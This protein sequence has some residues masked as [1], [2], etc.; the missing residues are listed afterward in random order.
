M[1]EKFE[2]EGVD[3][4]NRDIVGKKKKKKKKGTGNKGNI[5]RDVIRPFSRK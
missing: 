1:K 5:P 3:A 4:K 2:R